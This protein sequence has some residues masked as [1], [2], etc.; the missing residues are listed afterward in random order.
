M[1][2]LLSNLPNPKL[3][4]MYLYKRHMHS[5]RG[6]VIEWRL[7]Q[8]LEPGSLSAVAEWPWPSYL[9]L[10]II[11][12][13][14]KMGI[15]RMIPIALSFC[16]DKINKCLENAENSAECWENIINGIAIMIITQ[17]DSLMIFKSFGH[18]SLDDSYVFL[19]QCGCC[20]MQVEKPCLKL[21]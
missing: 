8:A 5:L 13:F 15:V 9:P 11:F 14:C 3:G 21:P 20:L 1:A 2:S 19:D 6:S 16:E 18:R 12:Y 7:V 10:L 4:E 17:I